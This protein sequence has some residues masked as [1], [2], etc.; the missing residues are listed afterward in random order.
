MRNVSREEIRS[1]A[2][3][4]HDG[5]VTKHTH[6]YECTE[7]DCRKRFEINQERRPDARLNE[8]GSNSQ[9]LASLGLTFVERAKLGF[10]P[11]GNREMQGIAAA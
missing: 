5:S 3:R 4:R 6:T 8:L 2:Y 10:K 11:S 7:A 1:R 9:C